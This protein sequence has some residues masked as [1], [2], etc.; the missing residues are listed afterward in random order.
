MDDFRV[1]RNI[2]ILVRDLYRNFYSAFR[3]K[4]G[5]RIF[6][7]DYR[8]IES[9]SAGKTGFIYT[10]FFGGLIHVI[11]VK[12]VRFCDLDCLE[13][14]AVLRDSARFVVGHG[15]KIISAVRC[16]YSLAYDLLER[17]RLVFFC[18]FCN[19]SI[20]FGSLFC[21]FISLFFR[22]VTGFG[23]LCFF[24]HI[25]SGRLRY[26]SNRFVTYNC[27][28]DRFLLFF[29]CRHIFRIL[30]YGRFRFRGTLY[31]R[32]LVLCFF[33]LHVFFICR[34]NGLIGILCDFY[35]SGSDLLFLREDLSLRGTYI[36]RLRVLQIFCGNARILGRFFRNSDQT[37]RRD[38]LF[39]IDRGYEGCLHKLHE[40]SDNKDRC[41]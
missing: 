7:T 28:W 30:R 20:C 31:L 38:I 2:R 24:R 27:L 5:C 34:E 29:V 36:S 12:S 25:G 16:A 41:G 8:D 39:G 15:N 17:Q 13:H 18:G 6:C 26:V 40:H 14:R 10:E 11:S 33:F 37:V 21:R 32:N 9:D 22:P 1:L 3:F 35:I 19:L 4:F 23:G